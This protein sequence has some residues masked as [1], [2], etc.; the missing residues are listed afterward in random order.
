LEMMKQVSLKAIGRE[1]KKARKKLNALRRSTRD[2]QCRK[3]LL[4]KLKGLD[5]VTRQVKA[6]CRRLWVVSGG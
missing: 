5:A 6:I 1:I 4:K 2:P 3:D